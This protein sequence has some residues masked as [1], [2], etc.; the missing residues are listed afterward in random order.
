[1]CI[2]EKDV[3]VSISSTFKIGYQVKSSNYD[4]IDDDLFSPL[5]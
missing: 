1:M 3:K 5:I 4:H 2:G